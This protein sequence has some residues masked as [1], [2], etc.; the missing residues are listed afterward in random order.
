MGMYA[1]GASANTAA[2]VKGSR[3]N[4]DVER[5]LSLARKIDSADSRV[6]RHVRALGYDGPP[7]DS[8]EIGGK[9]S[10]ISNS[11]QSAL[12]DLERSVDSLNGSL[13]LFD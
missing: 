4:S 11:L 7:T 6:M 2:E 10:P 9:V 3:I 12:N 1:G 13:N 5:I 8:P